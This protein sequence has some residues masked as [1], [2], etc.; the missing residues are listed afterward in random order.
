MKLIGSLTSPYVR[1]VRVVMAEKKLDYQ[2][3]LEDVW[4]N[5]KMLKSNPLGKVPC[6]VLEGREAERIGLVHDVYPDDQFDARVRDFCLNLAKQPPETIGVA[7]IAIEL[8]ADLD[9]AQARNVERLTASSLYFG[10]EF[11]S[12]LA[13]LRAKLDSKK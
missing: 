8:T 1:K 7:K 12:L 5:D 4:G 9:R 2:L 10:D 3:D 11:R 13:A 6:L